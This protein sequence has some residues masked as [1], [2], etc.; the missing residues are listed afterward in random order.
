M[1]RR[2]CVYWTVVSSLVVSPF[3]KI[4]RVTS[5]SGFRSHVFLFDNF[6]EDVSHHFL[7]DRCLQLLFREF[8]DLFTS[9]FTTLVFVFFFRIT[10][11]STDGLFIF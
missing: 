1:Q 7:V 2:Q 4:T 11:F 6:L 5:F 3:L 10:F 8:W 9:G